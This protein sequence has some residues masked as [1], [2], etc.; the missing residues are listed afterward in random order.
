MKEYS[1]IYANFNEVQMDPMLMDC[2]FCREDNLFFQHPGLTKP[3]SDRQKKELIVVIKDIIANN[4]TQCQRE[5]V[6]L[7]FFYQ[8]TETDIA[9]I[10]NR[11]QTTI[12]QH[13]RYGLKKIRKILT[14]RGLME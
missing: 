6:E 13:L 3:L 5:T 1:E 8:K 14:K 7:Y 11:H 9:Q 4:L 2:L 12:S 10:L